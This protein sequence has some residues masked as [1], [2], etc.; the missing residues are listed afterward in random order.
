MA[1]GINM[2][3]KSILLVLF[4]LLFLFPINGCGYT[5]TY[6][7]D[8]YWEVAIAGSWDD[9]NLE[10]DSETDGAHANDVNLMD[11]GTWTEGFRPDSIIVTFTGGTANKIYIYMTSSGEDIN[12]NVTEI[13]SGDTSPLLYPSGLDLWRATFYADDSFSITNIVFEIDGSL[14]GGTFTGFEWH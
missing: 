7:D 3:I 13:S 5:E 10:W 4:V 6:F 8:N 12:L 1:L 9:V 14:E 11:I 2:K